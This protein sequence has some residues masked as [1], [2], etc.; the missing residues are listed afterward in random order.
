MKV[1]DKALSSSLPMD[2]GQVW[3]EPR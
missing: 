3:A 1:I 2:V